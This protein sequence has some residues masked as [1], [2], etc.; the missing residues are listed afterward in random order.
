MLC[1]IDGEP[2]PAGHGLEE[3]KTHTVK[4]SVNSWLASGDVTTA[5]TILDVEGVTDLLA[6]ADKMPP[7]WIAATNTAGAKARGKLPR[8]WAKGKRVIV[9]GDADEPGAEGQRRAALAYHTAG[10]IVSLAQ[11]PYAVQETHG[12]D[13]RDFFGDCYEIEQLATIPMETHKQKENEHRADLPNETSNYWE[14]NIV[15]MNNITPR[16]VEWLWKN[17]IPNGKLV[18]LSGNPGLGKTLVLMDIAA[19]VSLGSDWPDGEPGDRQPGGVVICSAEDDPHDTLRPRLDAAGA[20]VSRINLVQSVVLMDGKTK[21]KSERLIDLQQDR[22]V[23]GKAMDL[24][25]NCKLLIMDPINAYLGKTDSHKNAEVRQ[26]LGPIAELCHRKG[27]AF[28]YLGHLN[29]SNS[30]PALYRAAGSIAFVAAARVA[31]MV[32]ESKEDPNTRLFLPVKNNLAPNIGGLSFQVVAVNDLPR[33][34]WNDA[35]ISMTADEALSTDA[36]GARG[37]AE[38]DKDWLTQQLASGAVES[39]E[40]FERGKVAGISR[41]RL[42]KAKDAVGAAAKKNGFGA[43]AKFEWFIP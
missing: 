32:V 17:R 27:V 26:I 15:A 10:A 5:T 31:Y 36:R 24:T 22:D 4:G 21:K 23:I 25:A 39:A 12:K 7:G 2:F 35:A 34:E 11:L 37:N 13:L 43:D 3:H 20:D 29:K 33:V 9:A 19:R 30:G 40:L 8:Q 28:I 6:A 1:R 41:N 14:P 42:F 16:A 18:S 38:H